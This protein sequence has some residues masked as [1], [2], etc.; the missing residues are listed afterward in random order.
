MGSVYLH[1]LLAHIFV[2]ALQA[3]SSPEPMSFLHA[4][5]SSEVTHPG[6]SLL[7][8]P[9]LQKG[10]M[11]VG[12]LRMPY[13]A[14]RGSSSPPARLGSSERGGG[15]SG[16][17]FGARELASVSSVH[18]WTGDPGV[19]LLRRTPATCSVPVGSPS[20]SLHALRGDG[21]GESSGAFIV[22]GCLSHLI[23][24]RSARW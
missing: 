18:S 16:R 10:E 4:G 19:A 5:T 23:A 9:F 20:S 21:A 24:A 22:L 2:F 11:G 14:S 13:V 6:S 8:S 7:L 17:S 12:G 1:Y 3:L 15:A